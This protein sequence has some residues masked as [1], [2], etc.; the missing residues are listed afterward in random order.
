MWKAKAPPATAVPRDVVSTGQNWPWFVPLQHWH[1]TNLSAVEDHFMAA[2][3][4]L[5]HIAMHRAVDAWYDCRPISG[6][7]RACPQSMIHYFDPHR[8]TMTSEC[9][10]GLHLREH[11]VRWRTDARFSYMMRRS[12]GA[13]NMSNPYTRMMASYAHPHENKERYERL[14]TAVEE[15]RW[16][17]DLDS[18]E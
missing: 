14:A 6:Y 11:G 18:D 1:T 5:A 7:V 13:A 9:F 2:P 12:P 4:D 17:D 3:R 16:G 10:L 8:Y 15:Q